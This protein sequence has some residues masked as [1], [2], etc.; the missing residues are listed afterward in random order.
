MSTQ[1][2]DWAD[3]NVAAYFRRV[4]VKEPREQQFLVSPTLSVLDRKKVKVDGDEVHWNVTYT[5]DALNGPINPDSILDLSEVHDT[6][7]A[8]TRRAIYAEAARINNDTLNAIVTPR[9]EFNLWAHRSK[10]ANLRLKKKLALDL[11]GVRSAAANGSYPIFGLRDIIADDPTSN[12]TSGT[13][14][15]DRST[16]TWF[17][18]VAVTG[19]GAFTSNGVDAMEQATLEVST[20]GGKIDVWVT[21]KAIM[22]KIKT[23]MR[24]NPRWEGVYE[25]PFKQRMADFGIEHVGFNGALIMVDPY[26]DLAGN[27]SRI[28]GWDS[29]AFYLGYYKWFEQASQAPVDLL[30]AGHLAKA[31]AFELGCQLVCEEPRLTCVLAGVS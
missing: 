13:Y 18:N 10:K 24:V 28:Y 12:P 5:G 16:Y 6:E 8:R 9:A 1:T 17:R 15:L 31:L 20:A 19:V 11:F 14:G 3:P 25:G 22:K 26:M 4:L 7:V 21:S 2:L 29:D 30:P 23:A 27:T